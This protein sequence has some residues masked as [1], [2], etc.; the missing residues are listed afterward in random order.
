MSLYP[1]YYNSTKLKQ[2]MTP[3]HLSHCIDSVRQSVQC[4]ADITPM[5]GRYHTL[6]ERP[7]IEYWLHSTHI[8][9]DFD[10]IK[11][12]AEKRKVSAAFV[13]IATDAMVE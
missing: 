12:W 9:R 3:D 4:S 11:E 5:P 2:M 1:D 10:K 8:C 6:P 13:K 7:L